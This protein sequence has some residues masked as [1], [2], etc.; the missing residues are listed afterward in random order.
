[1]NHDAYNF[2]HRKRVKHENLSNNVKVT[3]TTL[4]TLE[5][6]RPAATP[7]SPTEGGPAKI[8]QVV[9]KVAAGE[10]AQVNTFLCIFTLQKSLKISRLSMCN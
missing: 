3:D 1:M 8:E 9:G 10:K 2:Y 5:P 4:L 6:E 7:L